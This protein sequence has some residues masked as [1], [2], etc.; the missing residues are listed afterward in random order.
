MDALAAG[1]PDWAVFARANGDPADEAYF[2]HDIVH[3]IGATRIG[4]PSCTQNACGRGWR[5][6]TPNRAGRTRIPRPISWMSWDR[7][8]APF[9]KILGATP[10]LIRILS[11]LRRARL[12]L[13]SAHPSSGRCYG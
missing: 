2:L 6:V 1:S 5:N 8:H 3:T 13:L 9:G 7:V 10:Q 12:L 11:T 4:H